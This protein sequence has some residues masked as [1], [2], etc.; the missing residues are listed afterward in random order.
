VN[1]RVNYYFQSGEDDVDQIAN[2]FMEMF[3]RRKNGLRRSTCDFTTMK[4]FT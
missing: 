1:S 4:E 3:E 2:I